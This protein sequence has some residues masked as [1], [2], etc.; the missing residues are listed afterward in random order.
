MLG[1]VLVLVHVFDFFGDRGRREGGECD[2]QLTFWRY[3]ATPRIVP[4]DSRM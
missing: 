2:F 3:S 4:A 1:M